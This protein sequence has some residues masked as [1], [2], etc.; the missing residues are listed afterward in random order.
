MNW[1]KLVV[2]N[3][4]QREERKNSK[5]ERDKLA[6]LNAVLIKSI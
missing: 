1:R 6:S 3:E 2:E 5:F 4:K